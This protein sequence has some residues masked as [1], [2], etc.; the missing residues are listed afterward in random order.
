MKPCVLYED[1]CVNDTCTPIL[2][3]GMRKFCELNRDPSED[4]ATHPNR[5]TSRYHAPTVG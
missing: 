2:N 5:D 1:I 4:C 3:E